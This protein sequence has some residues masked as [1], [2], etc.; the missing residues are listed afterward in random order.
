MRKKLL[1][2]RDSEGTE[3]LEAMLSEFGQT[4]GALLHQNPVNAMIA[5]TTRNVKSAMADLGADAGR[6][7]TVYV[8]SALA[9]D[10][11][12][13]MCPYPDGS[14]L[15]QVSDAILSLCTVYAAFTG[16]VFTAI[17]SGSRPRR[18]WRTLRAARQGSL[19]GDPAVLTGLLRYYNVNQRVY[20]LSARLEQRV[21]DEAE[22]I[23]ALISGHAA[24]FVIGH[25]VAHHVLN[26]DSAP[27]SFSPGEYLP[28]CSADQQRELDADLLAYR[29]TVRAGERDFADLPAGPRPPVNVF[30]MLGALTAMLAIHLTEQAHF[31]RRGATHPPA[32]ARAA[33]LLGQLDPRERQFID[34]FAHN[35]LA[36]TRSSSTFDPSATPFDWEWFAAAPSISSAQPPTYLHQIWVLDTLQCQAVSRLV[37]ILEQVSQDSNPLVGTGAH[38]AAEGSVEQAL[39]TWGV[40]PDTAAHVCDRRTAVTFHAI[41]NDLRTSLPTLNISPDSVWG[42]CVAA[43][44]LAAVGLVV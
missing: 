31:V 16:D 43:A 15:V 30:P 12:A 1:E 19:G 41:V 29:A 39:R 2:L 25:E 44:Q 40:A 42:A 37:E 27:S 20:G 14:G 32:A 18:M 38:L 11:Y 28:A 9:E 13:Q 33:R 8:G 7:A 24:R 5:T 6:L 4:A 36:A 17:A 23:A 34:M 22:G 26:H 21:T 10:V 3:R 35:L